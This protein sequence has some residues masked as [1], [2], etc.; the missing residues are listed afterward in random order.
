MLK[1]TYPKDYNPIFEYWEAIESGKEVVSQKVYK[2]YQKVVY[3]L[4]DKTSP[5][6]FSNS[7]ANHAL[8]FIEN[9]CIQSKGKWGGK[10]VK[11][12][13][14][15]KAMLATIFGFIDAQGNRKYREAILIVGKKNGKSLLASCIG[16]YMMI[17]DNE[18]GAEIYSVATTLNQAKIIWLESKKMVKSSPALRIYIK[19]LTSQMTS[20]LNNSIFM[21]LAS[22]ANSGQN[23]GISIH[24]C[25]IDELHAWKRGKELYDILARGV[26][27]REQPLILVTST[28]GTIRGDIFDDKYQEATN[29][30]N[31]YFNPNGYHDEQFISFIYE[32]DDKK[33]FTD[34]KCWKKANPN[35]GVTKSYEYVEKEVAKAKAD[36]SQVKN[37]LCKE[38]NIRE[39]STEVALHFDELTNL[40]TFS[41]KELKPKYGI[42]GTDLSQCIDLTAACVL[43]RI[44]N[45]NNIYV[46]HMYWMPEELL[47]KREHEDAVPYRQWHDN[48]WIRTCPGNRINEKVVIEWFL[49]LQNEYNLYLP[50]VG[51]DRYSAY[52]FVEELKNNFGAKCPIPIA[53]GKQT[54]S[55]PLLTMLADFRSHRIVYNNNPVTQYCLCNLKLDRDKKNGTVQPIKV[56]ERARIDGVAAMLDAFVVYLDRYEEYMSMI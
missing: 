22:D 3:D 13:L 28:A 31:G 1:V 29:V 45:D 42:G 4:N 47:E 2:T 5:Y 32:L 52:H 20:S 40:T 12:E 10:P 50:Y 46:E 36:P 6:H 39:T 16:L 49:E 26:S 14:W 24:C 34:T 11:L 17:A 44:P 15:E 27:S 37:V 56:N 18:P 7:R 19:P 8:E 53:Q 33:E 9:F 25:L 51:Y 30:I 38:F 35:L 21:P 23:D 48:G 41:L 55:S 43:F 54:L